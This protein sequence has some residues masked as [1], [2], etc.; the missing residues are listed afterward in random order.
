[1]S[2][3]SSVDMAARLRTGDDCEIGVRVH[4]GYGLSFFS[5]ASRSTLGPTQPSALW[6]PSVV[7]PA[8]NAAGRE[9]ENTPPSSD[10]VKIS[11]TITVLPNTSSCPGA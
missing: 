4:A 6:S 10:E 8:G 2:W 3:V 11:G 7:F 9:A 1:M 5:K